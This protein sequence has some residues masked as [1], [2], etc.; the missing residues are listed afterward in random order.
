MY[1]I[2]SI[3]VAG[4]IHELGHYLAAKLFGKTIVFRRQ[5]VRFLWDMPEGLNAEQ[6]SVVAL[7][8]FSL[9]MLV[10]LPL[11]IFFPLQGIIYQSVVDVHFVAYHFYAGD[12]NDFSFTTNRR[13]NA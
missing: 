3:L 4:F 10:A 2:L 12:N 1:T 11:L 6:A 7:A 13:A 9:E 8:G 5:G